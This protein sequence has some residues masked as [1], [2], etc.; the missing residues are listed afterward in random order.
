MVAIDSMPGNICTSHPSAAAVDARI[1]GG[2]A[3]SNV[4]LLATSAI[5]LVAMRVQQCIGCC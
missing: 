4:P 2:Y 5:F 3:M 1:N